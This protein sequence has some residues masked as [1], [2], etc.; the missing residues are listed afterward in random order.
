MRV[1]LSL[2]VFLWLFLAHFVPFCAVLALCKGLTAISELSRSFLCKVAASWGQ[3]DWS[4]VTQGSL[5]QPLR[6]VY[7]VEVGFIVSAYANRRNNLQTPR[8][9]LPFC[10]EWVRRES[11][12]K[13]LD[14]LWGTDREMADILNR[15]DSFSPV[16]RHPV[17]SIASFGP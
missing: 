8:N 9:Y 5:Q 12:D 1:K 3:I 16:N 10:F 17:L 14:I 15:G 4:A 2:G 11:R 6:L 7:L 13:G